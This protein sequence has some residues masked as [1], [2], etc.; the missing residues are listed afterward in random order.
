MRSEHSRRGIP[1]VT[2]I[3]HVAYNVPDMEQALAFF[4]NVL[5]CELLARE[6]PH[7]MA[8]RPGV[9]VATAVLR[10]DDAVDFELLEF[11]T[12]DQT[13]TIPR[14]TDTGGYHLALSCTDIPAA[15]AWL[16]VALSSDIV[17]A[18]PL[19]NGRRRAFFTT[20]WGLN[21]QIIEPAVDSIF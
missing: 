2:G 7:E 17:E 20:P 11:H 9:Q 6:Y 15:V 21:V 19:K 5:G 3:D 16:R 13:T 14:M 12:A 10:Y 18:E 1:A 4:I 8:G